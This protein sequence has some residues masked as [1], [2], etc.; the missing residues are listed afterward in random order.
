LI[1]LRPV[2]A[3]F[4]KAALGSIVIY[5]ASRLIEIPEFVRLYRFRLSEFLLALA[6]SLGVLFTSITNGVLVAMLLSLLEFLIRI[7]NPTDAVL[8]KSALTTTIEEN[9]TNAIPLHIPGLVIYRYDAPLFFANA[10]NFK[11]R[12]LAAL[13]QVQPNIHWLVV[14]AEAIGEVD[15]TAIEMLADLHEELTQQGIRFS[16]VAVKPRVLAEFQRAGFIELVGADQFFPTMMAVRASYGQLLQ[17]TNAE[18][19]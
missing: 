10:D 14:N 16:W 13:E 2:L 8:G 18:T 17:Y 7:A 4:P 11:C 6:T 12:V 15:I 5:A 19:L 9:R 1:F 3:L